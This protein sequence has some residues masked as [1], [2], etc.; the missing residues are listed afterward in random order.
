MFRKAYIDRLVGKKVITLYHD[1]KLRTWY[2]VSQCTGEL[3]P[4]SIRGFITILKS[5]KH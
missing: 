3:Q 4:V 1:P 5:F 2:L